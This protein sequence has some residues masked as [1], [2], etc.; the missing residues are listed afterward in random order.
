LGELKLITRAESIKR[1]RKIAEEYQTIHG[2]EFE[3]E[4]RYLPLSL[5]VP[6]QRELSEA[7]LLV[8]LQ[9]I[10]HGYDA[11]VIVVPYGEKYYILDG[12]HRA[13]AL[14][15]LGFKEVEALVIKDGEDFVP[16]VV[17][18]A[19]KSGLKSLEDIEIRKK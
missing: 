5:L 14:W 11:P 19:E 6:T 13:F 8:V 18:T 12:H 1:A 16:G 15:K 17:R 3:V 7:K 2:R 4:R 9:E 10:K